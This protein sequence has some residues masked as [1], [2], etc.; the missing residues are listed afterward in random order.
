MTTMPT[1]YRAILGFFALTTIPSLPALAE[2]K[3]TATKSVTVQPAGPRQ[4]EAGSRY[5]NVEGSRNDRYASFGVLAFGLPKDGGQG[6]DVKTMSL[7]LVQS[8]PRFARDGKVR[9]CLAEPHD[10][11]TDPLPGLKF[12]RKSPN[13]VGT[14]AFKVLHPLGAGTFAKVETGNTDTFELKPNE[15]GERYLRYRLKGGGTI[16]IVVVPD[17]EEVAATYFGVGAEPEGNRPR[18]SLDSGSVK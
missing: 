17:G 7:W 18:L 1:R 11:G 2:I 9:F 10:R 8:I 12:D 13:G 5:F 4:G 15:T 6:G 14:D 16:V 3:V